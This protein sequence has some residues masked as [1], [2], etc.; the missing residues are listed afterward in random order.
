MRVHQVRSSRVSKDSRKVFQYLVDENPT[1]ITEDQLGISL[2]S[3]LLFEFEDKY[4]K[5]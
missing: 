1:W 3:K 2:S 5:F 4:L